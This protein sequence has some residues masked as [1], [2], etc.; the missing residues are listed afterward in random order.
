[1][2]LLFCVR[3]LAGRLQVLQNV[4]QALLAQAY[5]TRSRKVLFVAMV[6][7]ALSFP[8]TSCAETLV[9]I[10]GYLGSADN[11]HESG[12]AKIL[13]EAGWQDAG[14]LSLSPGGVHLRGPKTAA[15]KRFFTLDLPT[16]APLMVQADVLGRY[17]ADLRRRYPESALILVGHSAGGVSARLHMVREPKAGVAALITLASPHLGTEMAELGL[18]AGQSPLAWVAPFLGGGTL[19][20]S[21]ALY[22]DL[23]RQSPSNLLGWLNHQPHPP[24]LYVSIVRRD[25]TQGLSLGNLIV[26]AWSQD[27][28]RVF[29]LRGRARTF[30]VRGTHRL[31]SDDGRWILQA[32][33]MLNRV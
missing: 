10:Q 33:N 17:L 8:G 25:D 4:K 21:Q 15:R 30:T 18:M 23:A 20:R 28:N 29:A 2:A 22:H 27:M 32:L 11:W 26:P 12:V 1:M 19:N 13:V 16:E 7:F 6:L 5:R 14:R 9:F 24:A 3:F 31:R